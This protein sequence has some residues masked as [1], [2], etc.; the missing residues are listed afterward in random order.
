MVRIAGRTEQDIDYRKRFLQN[1]LPIEGSIT[2]AISKA[3]VNAAME[4]NAKAIVT[5]T[6]SGRTA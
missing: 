1:K 4:L 2:N 5:V 6:E 3:T